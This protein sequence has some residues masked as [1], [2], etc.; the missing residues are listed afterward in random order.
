MRCTRQGDKAWKGRAALRLPGWPPRRRNSGEMGAG[1]IF[2]CAISA[3]PLPIA[4]RY[5]VDTLHG[6]VLA[7]L[8]GAAAA[9]AG[10]GIADF[11]AGLDDLHRAS[12]IL[13]APA[14][15][16]RGGGGQHQGADHVLALG[17][18]GLELG[19]GCV[20]DS[21]GRFLHAASMRAPR[22]RWIGVWRA[23]PL[24]RRQGAG[25]A[26]ENI[27][28]AP[29]DKRVDKRADKASGALGQKVRHGLL[30]RLH[31]V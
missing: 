20:G 30:V 17:D 10:D 6:D 29:V 16:G 31:P 5:G 19:F 28:A 3:T 1:R 21:R 24:Y 25:A 11:G 26:T 13:D 27:F 14:I 22:G 7:M 12:E 23:R 8:A 15:V 18:Q 4:A 2:V 9:Q